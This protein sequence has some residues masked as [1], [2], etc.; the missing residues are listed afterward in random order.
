MK[1][2]AAEDEWKK[3]L[4]EVE[5]S[6]K[7]RAQ[8]SAAEHESTVKRLEKQLSEV[9]DGYE[10]TIKKLNKQLAQS[11]SATEQELQRDLAQA[12]DD[13]ERFMRDQSSKTN[14]IVK[15]TLPESI[16]YKFEGGVNEVK[17]IKSQRDALQKKLD[18]LEAEY[19]SAGADSVIENRISELKAELE[20][21]RAERD[22]DVELLTNRFKTE[23]A[24]VERRMQK[25]LEDAR[26]SAE[27]AEKSTR[28]TS[29]SRRVEIR[30]FRSRK[31]ARRTL[32]H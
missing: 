28:K 13:L 19:A 14:T 10:S 20:S 24:E 11:A 15:Y 23:N 26:R 7:I 5:N 1:L 9:R 6:A 30:S 22:R 32:T 4:Q 25:Q 16:T 27:T 8:E 17:R 21:T 29:V 3:K 2:K 31:G 12:R 18:R